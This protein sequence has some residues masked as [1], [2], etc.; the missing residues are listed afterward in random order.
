MEISAEILNQFYQ[1]GWE[2]RWISRLDRKFIPG[3]AGFKYRLFTT[4]KMLKFHRGEAFFI[5]DLGCGVGI[6]DIQILKSFKKARSLAVDLSTEQIKAARMLV[7]KAGVQD[8]IDFEAADVASF[9]AQI[10]PNLILATEILEHLPDPAPVLENIKRTADE[11][12]QIIISVPCKLHETQNDWVYH[13]QITGDN[14]QNIQSEK[15]EELNNAE[16]QYSFYHKEYT[17]QE[18]QKVLTDRGFVINRINFCYYQYPEHLVSGRFKRKLVKLL[19][20]LNRRIIFKPM[21]YFLGYILG[22]NY[23]ETIILDC[24]LAKPRRDK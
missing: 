22:E 16:P 8:R 2:Q 21:D 6:Y 13:R 24:A 18:I 20:Y 4:L 14:W 11:N 17:P 19:N 5:L 15:T 9:S 23:F 1:V 10:K 12:T 7:N 3:E